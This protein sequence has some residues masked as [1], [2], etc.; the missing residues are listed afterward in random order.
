MTTTNTH[1]LPAA[2][3]IVTV[4]QVLALV[5]ELANVATPNP[6]NMIVRFG[7]IT[8]LR[9]ELRPSL[10]STGSGRGGVLRIPIDAG[11]LALWEDVTARVQALPVDLGDEPATKGSLEQILNTWARGL[12]AADAETR[13]IQLHNGAPETGLN[14]DALRTMHRRLS[15]IRD[16]IDD[17]FNP[18]R[19]VEYPYCP[20]CRNTHV[21]QEVDG[22]DIQQRAL[23]ATF[24]PTNP[25]RPALAACAVCGATWTDIAGIETLN[26]LLTQLAAA[27]AWNA[28]HEIGTLVSVEPLA[29]PAEHVQSPTL[30]EA[31]LDDDQVAAAWVY[32]A[33]GLEALV[34][35]TRLT[36]IE[37]DQ[38]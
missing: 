35:L 17:H 19:R 2:E 20:E 8:E 24:W 1:A 29:M 30:S 16:L 12:T 38:S 6:A 18:P 11:A 32:V 7:L 31:H 37:G 26:E 9:Q 15:R 28:K 23:T 22:E 27:A 3:E 33:V 13:R 25:G 10:G 36:P 4:D 21:L 34:P 5:D 14:S